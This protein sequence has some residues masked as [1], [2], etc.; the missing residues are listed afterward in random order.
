MVHSIK[1]S[2]VFPAKKKHARLPYNSQRKYFA[3]YEYNNI[4][5]FN[6]LSRNFK[7]D[8]VFKRFYYWFIKLNIFD[9]EESLSLFDQILATRLFLFLFIISNFVL[10]LFNGLTLHTYS[11]TIQSP[12]LSHFEYLN[13]RYENTLNCPCSQPNIDY[14]EIIS[15]SP[16]YH[17]VCSS[18]FVTQTF[19]SSFF[20]QKI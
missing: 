7:K 19:I 14:N 2:T 15:F 16:E 3:F 20:T 11:T 9:N 4:F 6:Y 13:Y 5:L 12:S 18:Q 8:D 17:Q 10:V 1:Y